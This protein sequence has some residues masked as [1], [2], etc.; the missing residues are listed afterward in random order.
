MN[1]LLLV[2]VGLATVAGLTGLLPAGAGRAQ[3]PGGSNPEPF[4]VPV[5]PAGAGKLNDAANGSPAWAPRADVVP[6]TTYLPTTP[7]YQQPPAAKPVQ[8]TNDADKPGGLREYLSQN[9]KF[10]DLN[11]DIAVQPGCGPWMICL[12]WYSGPEAP[13]LARDMVME[14]RSN[15]DYQL[16]AYV[17]TKGVEE[18]QAELKRAAEY[19]QR[20][21]ARL[22][23]AGCPADTHIRVPMV[24]YEIQCAVLVGG[25]KD[26]DAAH[27]ALEQLKKLK[28]PDPKKVQMHSQII[29]EFYKDGNPKDGRFAPINPFTHGMVVPNPTMPAERANNAAADMG[30]LRALNADEPFSLLKCPKKYTLAITKYSLSTIIQSKKA[31]SSFWDKLGM[32]EPGDKA[33]GAGVSAHNL[34]N[35]LRE[36]KFEAYV[37]HSRHCSYVTVGSYD[38]SDDPRIKQDQELLLR[39]NPQL[40]EAAHLVPRPVVMEVPK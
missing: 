35:L 5:A 25:Y 31:S 29:V 39:L 14:L 16:P 36:G 20:E 30:L 2:G 23:A 13:K 10:V 21:R 28:P 11:Q 4:S 40:R 34:A 3:N 27:R 24:R 18:C 15:P 33:D 1:K 6:T 12:H 32:G 26:M 22:A 17:F 7:G 38:S 8:A 9:L 19:V 37:L